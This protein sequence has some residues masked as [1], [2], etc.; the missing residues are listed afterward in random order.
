MNRSQEKIERNY[1]I[2]HLVH[3]RILQTDGIE[4]PLRR[5]VNTMGLISQAGF[6][7]SALQAD[8]TCIPIENPLIR[9]YFRQNRHIPITVPGVIETQSAKVYG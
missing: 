5:F 6:E 3:A 4:Q 8:G 7:C 1:F 9:V 2:H